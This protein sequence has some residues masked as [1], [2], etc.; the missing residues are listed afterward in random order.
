MAVGGNSAISRVVVTGTGIEDLVVTGIRK[1][2]PGP[3]I[4]PAPGTVYQYAGL[5]PAGYH[6][7]TGAGITFS[8][9]LAWLAANRVSPQEIVLFRYSGNDWTAL[10]TTA[11]PEANGFAG[12]VATSPGLSLFAIT[13]LPQA[14]N[15]TTGA[16]GPGSV[17]GP[18]LPAAPDAGPAAGGGERTQAPAPVQP[19][20]PAGAAAGVP[21]LLIA[22][23]I[24]GSAGIAAGV[25]L[26]RRWWIR[27]QNPALFRKY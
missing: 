8:V 14:Q 21:L 3:G 9:P 6:S 17:P 13:A 12:F 18:V 5:T 15:V 10:P 16:P 2:Q 19:A 1:D 27:R 23:G 24:L 22:A 25:V 26:V 4:P 7:V 20:A 11:G